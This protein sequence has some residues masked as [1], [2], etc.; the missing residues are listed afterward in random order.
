[1]KQLEQGLDEEPGSEWR[2]R[3]KAAAHMPARRPA[4]VATAPAWGRAPRV[5]R[6]NQKEEEGEPEQ[7]VVNDYELRQR[8]GQ[9]RVQLRVQYGRGR[10]KVAVAGG[11]GGRSSTASREEGGP[12][13]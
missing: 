13:E 7:L 4:P 3:A 2:D 5:R 9:R 12:D 10:F 8:A 11:S 6:S 1:M